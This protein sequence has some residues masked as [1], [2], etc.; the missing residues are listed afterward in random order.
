MAKDHALCG[1]NRLVLPIIHQGPAT[2]AHFNYYQPT[3]T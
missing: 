1:A 2:W 3:E